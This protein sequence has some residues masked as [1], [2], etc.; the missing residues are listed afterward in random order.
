MSGFPERRRAPPRHQLN[1]CRCQRIIIEKRSWYYFL[2]Y[3]YQSS[4]LLLDRRTTASGRT[5]AGGRQRRHPEGRWFRMC[6][7]DGQ[8]S[9]AAVFGSVAEALRMAG[10]SLDY[11]NSPAAA[12]LPAAACGQ[13][14]I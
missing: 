11:L 8:A 9:G 3:V 7:P 13:V 1:V 10:A 12:D 6:A 2:T 14:L 4:T 5:S